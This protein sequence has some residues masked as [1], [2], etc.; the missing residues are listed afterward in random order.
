VVVFCASF[1]PLLLCV[2]TAQPTLIYVTS[3]GPTWVRQDCAAALNSSTS[4]AIASSSSSSEVITVARTTPLSATE[5]QLLQN[6]MRDNAEINP[7]LRQFSFLKDDDN[8]LLVD[9]F[10]SLAPMAQV[11]ELL[12]VV[13]VVYNAFVWLC[14]ANRGS[15]CKQKLHFTF[16]NVYPTLLPF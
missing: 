1:F 10:K 3:G 5:K 14:F 8:H 15:I 13:I 6:N 11:C 7:Y 9:R 12:H 4:T 16:S 2:C